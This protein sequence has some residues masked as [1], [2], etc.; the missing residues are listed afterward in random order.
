MYFEWNEEK[1]ILLKDARN[2]S[3]EDIV[4]AV[5]N[6]KI[7]DFIESPTHENQSCFVVAFNRYAYIVPFVQKDGNTIFLKTIYPS[8]KHTKFYNLKD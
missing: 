7:L 4:M 5:K 2:I 3:F 6:E 8:R 1:N